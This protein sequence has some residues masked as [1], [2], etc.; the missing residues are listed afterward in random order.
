[1]CIGRG[2]CVIKEMQTKSGSRIQIPSQPV[3]GMGYRIATI[4]GPPENCSA[5]KQ[6]IDRIIGEQ[7][8]QSVMTGAA[9]TGSFSQGQQEQQQGMQGQGQQYGQQYGA[10]GAQQAGAYAQ[11]A[12]P[13]SGQKTDYSAEWAAYYAQQAASGSTSA[14]ASTPAPAAAASPASA[15]APVASG[16]NAQQPAADS[17]YDAFFRYAVYYGEAAARQYYGAWSPPQGTPNP[18][19]AA[20][21]GAS[22]APASA[23]VS[24]GMGH[25]QQSAPA[26]AQSEILDTS[27]RRGVSNLPAWMTKQSK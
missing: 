26:P 8:S 7:S 21:S 22:V 9:F 19:G 2:G 11:T 1:M 6:M 27:A 15:P 14:S 12:Q 18:Y 25:P 16:G 20:G 10:Y 13:S 5:V 3:P 17:Y 24:T 23:A 4:T